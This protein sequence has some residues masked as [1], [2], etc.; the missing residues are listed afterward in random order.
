LDFK[1]EKDFGKILN[2]GIFFEDTEK[3]LKWGRSAKEIAKDLEIKE[4]RFADRT[5]YNWG[6]QN[7]LG[8]LKL[9]LVQCTGT[10]TK[11]AGIKY[12]AR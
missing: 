9:P 2:Q 4:K 12:L 11:R 5:V 6:E 10:I 7:I 3:F 1:N 8:G